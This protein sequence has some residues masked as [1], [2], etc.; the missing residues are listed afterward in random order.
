MAVNEDEKSKNDLKY[1]LK[2]DE[3]NTQ[4]EKHQNK[5]NLFRNIAIFPFLISFLTL[6]LMYMANVSTAEL[7]SFGVCNFLIGVALL[8][9]SSNHSSQHRKLQKSIKFHRRWREKYDWI[10]AVHKGPP[11]ARIRVQRYPRIRIRIEGA[12]SCILNFVNALI[13]A[14]YYFSSWVRFHMGKIHSGSQMEFEIYLNNMNK[15]I[16]RWE[17]WKTA[18]VAFDDSGCPVFYWWD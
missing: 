5:S 8:S 16:D 3:L 6:A 13:V 11:Y 7:E 15:N 14:K 9:I 17:T 18:K 12:P 4:K 1:L 10:C 2:M